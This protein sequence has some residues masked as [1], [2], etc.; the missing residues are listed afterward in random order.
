MGSHW[1]AVVALVAALLL[2]TSLYAQASIAG[3]VRDTSGAVLPGVTI[4]AASPVLIEKV[5]TVVT[6]GNGQFQIVELRPGAY[7]V[8]FTLPGFNTLRRDGIQL[9]GTFTATVDA[10]LRVGALEETVTV[11][12]E[13]PTVD[14]QSATR[15]QVLSSQVV[16]T[17]PTGRAYSSLAVLI[18][19]VQTNA[20]NVGGLLG[21]QMASL[22]VHGSKAADM[23]IQTNG[24]TN[25]SLQSSGSTSLS[26]PN[27]SAAQE[28]TVDTGA[29][30][31]EA[32][33]GGVR[34]NFIPRDGGNELRG[35]GYFSFAN[36][37]MQGNNL[38][39]R[40]ISQ[41]FRTSE[42]LNKVWDGNY[43]IGGPFKRDRVWFFHT[44]RYN[45]QYNNVAGMF[46][47]RNA[48]NPNAWTYDPDESQP[49][50]NRARWLD[51]QLR[52]TWQAT[53]KHKIAFTYNQQ[54]RRSD[55]FYAS[56]TRAPEAGNDRDSPHQRWLL[57]EWTSPMTNRVLVEAVASH[58]SYTWGNY[59]PGGAGWA[60]ATQPGMISVT[61]QS[62]GLIY[63]SAQ[64][65][66]PPSA[67][68]YSPRA[69][70]RTTSIVHRSRTSPA[71]MR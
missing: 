30:T 46:V 36:E 24:I 57:G 25:G 35:F 19:G 2:P 65:T 9:T 11:T 64:G 31:A 45:G 21:D 26:T 1:S 14:V 42:S 23:R 52:T 16:D 28:V 60:S 54:D 5:R 50:V 34:V 4:E 55:G 41:G 17:L 71:R 44:G 33:T 18:P 51:A 49:A 22:T 58:R 69:G 68:A 59:P 15:Q 56:A 67:P 48:N 38:T 7:T 43:G 27:V 10:E 13:T 3:S 47:N 29:G 12:G 39:D 20:Q 37:S 53:P 70:C 32:P 40:L 8:T 6:N 61:E 66:G 63:R 62:T